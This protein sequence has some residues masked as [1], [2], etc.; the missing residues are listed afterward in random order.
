MKTNFTLWAAP[1]LKRTALALLF[2]TTFSMLHAQKT[3][4]GANNGLWSVSS[5]WNPAGAPTTTTDVTIANSTNV[6]VDISNATARSII[7]ASSANNSTTTLTFNAGSQLTVSGSV[8]VG[9]NGNRV[10]RIVMTNGGTLKAGS[11][12][13]DP[14]NNVNNA[15]FTPGTGTVELT[16]TNIL[17][18]NANYNTFNNL[19]ITGATTTSTTPLNINGD[20]TGTGTL[21]Q[22]SG[23]I[24]IGGNWNR[25]GATFTASAAGVTLTGTGKGITGG[26]GLTF[27]TLTVNGT[28]T[29]NQTGASSL[30]VSTV[31]AGTGTLTQAANVNLNIGGTSS[32]TGLVA[33]ATGNTVTYNGTGQTVK[34]T[35]YHNLVLGGSGTKTLPAAAMAVAGNFTTSGTATATAGGALTIGGNVAIGA[36]TTFNAGNFTHNV[37]GNWTNA[38]TFNPGTGTI[39]FNSSTAQTI[40]ASIFYNIAFENGST[41]NPKTLSGDLIV[42][43][44]VTINAGAALDVS[45]SNHSISVGNNWVRG[46]VFDPRSGTVTLNGANQNI[47]AGIFYNLTFTSTNGGT[48]IVTGSDNLGIARNLTITGNNT[49]LDLGNTVADNTTGTGNLTIGSGATLRV[50]GSGSR[51]LPQNYSSYP[52]D[53]ASTVEFYGGGTRNILA[54]NYGNLVITGPTTVT[55]NGELNIAGNLTIGTGATLNG[56][57]GPTLQHTIQGN[58]INNGFYNAT[59]ATQFT[60][61]GSALQTISGSTQTEFENL[62][63]SNAAGIL[64]NTTTVIGADGGNGTLTFNTGIVN[65]ASGQLLIINPNGK[66]LGTPSNT[67]HVN[68]RVRKVGN[69]DFKFPIGN[70]LIYAPI[71]I[72]GGGAATDAFEAEYFRTSAVALDNTLTAPLKAVSNCEY[73]DLDRLVTTPATRDTRVTLYWSANS[74]CGGT[75]ITDPATL[76]VAHLKSGAWHSH[77]ATPSTGSDGTSGSITTS[78][79][80]DDFSPF[81][82][83]TINATL[84][85]LPVTFKSFEG[86][87]AGNGTQLTWKVADEVNVHE[88]QVERST[89]GN[90]GF[91]KIGTVSAKG[92]LNYAFTDEAPL[93]GQVYY[94]IKSLDNDGTFGYSNQISFKNG[95]STLVFR[96]FPTVVSSRTD[97]Q[98]GTVTGNEVITLTSADGRLVRSL[99][100]ATGS[101]K[102][103]V[104]MS[105]LRAGLYVLKYR[106]ANGNTETVKL[107][108]Q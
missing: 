16:G 20:L 104:E 82:I 105:D 71:G 19:V 37:S 56:T 15:L 6:V 59:G 43:N 7:L 28:Y 9:D 57:N 66:V 96:V 45:A 74:E 46:G 78:A 67:S 58:W 63:V 34:N 31:L 32:I 38:G 4:V 101:L 52:F 77:F 53:A 13:I 73:W 86:K 69:D 55:A 54:R 49:I 41:T 11:I 48:K 36:G 50:G 21:T 91:A 85:P 47:T 12:S 95:T 90:S 94:R 14:G 2:F 30:T 25:P 100:P 70:G 106:A 40:G 39:N 5:N 93:G 87:R 17:S 81:T 26:S 33:T 23:L 80:V 24:T 10:G 18:A 88:Y 97:V 102:T 99:R 79:V 103:T 64:I 98:H 42:T 83:G 108:K 22:G 44:N 72:G 76:R 51:I 68:G 62:G 84:N 92:L 29:N 35:S 3:W 8:S 1:A 60:F 89:T 65:V 75:Y 27:T 61:N 107:V